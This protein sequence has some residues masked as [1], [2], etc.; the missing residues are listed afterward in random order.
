[1]AVWELSDSER[2]QLFSYSLPKRETKRR[3]HLEIWVFPL[4]ANTT[5]FAEDERIVCSPDM[6]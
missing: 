6:T 4:F 5:E 2:R 1:M 3:K